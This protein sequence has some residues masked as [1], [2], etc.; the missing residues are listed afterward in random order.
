MYQRLIIDCYSAVATTSSLSVVSERRENELLP[1]LYLKTTSNS[2]A[3]WAGK[4]MSRGCVIHHPTKAIRKSQPIYF[5]RVIFATYNSF[6][7]APVAAPAPPPHTFVA[8]ALVQDCSCSSVL[9]DA[10]PRVPSDL[11]DVATW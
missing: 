6:I 7:V 10:P 4:G 8:E 1:W 2:V 9:R 5:T 3:T 11:V